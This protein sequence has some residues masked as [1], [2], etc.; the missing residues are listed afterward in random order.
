MHKNKSKYGEYT[1]LKLVLFEKKVNYEDAAK[2]A[3]LSK[4]AFSNKINGIVDF[5][6]DEIAKLCNSLDID[7]TTILNEK[8]HLATK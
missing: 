5:R 4:S 6:I 2:M 7:Y 3:D 8:L 1:K